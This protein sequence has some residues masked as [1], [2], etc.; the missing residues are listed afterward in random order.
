[1]KCLGAVESGG[2][3]KQGPDCKGKKETCF[4]GERSQETQLVS[5][6]NLKRLVMLPPY[7]KPEHS[8]IIGRAYAHLE[9]YEEMLLSRLGADFQAAISVGCKDTMARIQREFMADPIRLEMTKAIGIL[10]RMHN[11]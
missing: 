8:E 1:M 10:R 3:C 6:S 9:A 5:P 7:I 2:I 4:K 11:A